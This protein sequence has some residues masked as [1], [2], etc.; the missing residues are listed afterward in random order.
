[1]IYTE[2]NFSFSQPPF[3]DG[4]TVEG[5][6][7]T[8]LL[9]DTE[10][11]VGVE[12]VTV[13]GG[14]F[15][16]CKPPASWTLLGGNWCQISFCSHV[17]PD[18]VKHG[19]PVHAEDCEH[20]KSPTKSWEPIEEDEYRELYK[21]QDPEDPEATIPPKVKIDTY[22]D[23]DKVTI[24]TFRKEVYVYENKVVKNGGKVKKDHAKAEARP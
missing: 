6:N 2:G 1:M 4:D 24:Q 10:I 9:P 7:Y 16:N 21:A 17:R 14:N 15:V 20:R 11:C 23:G 3:S 22:K 5:G 8:Q 19:L 13:R 18:L 12:N